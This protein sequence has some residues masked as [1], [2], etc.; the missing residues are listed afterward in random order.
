MGASWADRKSKNLC[1]EVLSSLSLHNNWIVMRSDK[2][3]LYNN[4]W[5]PAQWLDQKEAPKHFPKP[6][7]HPK[8][9]KVMVTVWWS[10]SRLIHYSF[11]NPGETNTSEKYAQQINEMH[12]KLPRLQLT[13]VSRM[14]PILLCDKAW[15]RCTAYTSK[16]E[17]F[18]Q[19]SFASSAKF[20][21][22]LIN[23]LPLL[24]ASWQLFAWKTLP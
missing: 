19:Q 1:F 2:W 17:Q 23:G 14:G 13:L 24:Q 12:Q 21:W 22:P 16:V 8:N 9:K 15:P 18:G 20:T 6:K 3:I 10:V 11:L 5:Q 7:L 4:W